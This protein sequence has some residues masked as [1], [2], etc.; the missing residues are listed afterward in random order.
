MN[1]T[2]FVI[3]VAAGIAVVTIAMAVVATAPLGVIVSMHTGP[4]YPIPQGIA[5]ANNAFA[6]DFYRQ[7]AAGNGDDNIF[8]S[9]TGMYTAFSILYEGARNDTA[10]QMLGVFEFESNETARRDAMMRTMSSLNRG[11]PHS[12]LEL[13]NSVW[14]ADW[15]EPHDSYLDVA[16]GAFRA[17]VDKV[18]FQGGGVERINDWANERTHGKIKN[19]LVQEDVNALTAMVILNTIYFKGTWAAQFPV[20]DTRQSEFWKNGTHSVDA[21]FMNVD[22]VFNYSRFDGEQVLRMPYKGDRLSML[23]VLPDG[24]D[25]MEKL[26]EK[27]SLERVQEWQQYLSETEVIVSVPKFEMKTHYNLEPIL[28]SLGMTDAFDEE[29]ADLL[30]ILGVQP[31]ETYDGRNLYVSKALHDAYVK[32]NEEGTEAAAAT[33]VFSSE[34]SLPPPPPHFIADH[35]FIFIIQDDESG[36]ILFMGRVSDPTL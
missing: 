15:F 16:R 18:S 13:A 14:V 27:L 30:G 12:T 4:V 33:T 31:S 36:T 11:D 28:R 34:L 22:G 26:Q 23:V 5:S 7:L 19:V 6:V 17:S 10:E 8:F 29:L 2:A 32:V 1:R 21:D 3:A 9:P 24:R 20:E 25:G 35:P